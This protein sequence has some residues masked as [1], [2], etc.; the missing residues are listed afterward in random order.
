MLIESVTLNMNT[1]IFEAVVEQDAMQFY[2]HREGNRLLFPFL[3]FIK[4]ACSL[5]CSSL[6][7]CVLVFQWLLIPFISN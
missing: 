3:H 5:T 7:Y 1:S 2:L 4:I 6:L